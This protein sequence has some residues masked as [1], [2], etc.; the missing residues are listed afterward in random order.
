MK[1]SLLYSFQDRFADAES[2]PPLDWQKNYDLT[3]WEETDSKTV[4]KFKRKFD[5]CD[6]KDRKIEV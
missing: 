6:P 5:T 1:V 4:L 2:L 3:G